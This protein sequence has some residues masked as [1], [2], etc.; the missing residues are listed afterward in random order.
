MISRTIA[1]ELVRVVGKFP[2]VL[3]AGPRDAGKTTLVRSVL[4]GIQYVS[5]EDL[6]RRLFAESDPKGFLRSYSD[7]AILDE[8]QRVPELL[9]HLIELL[10]TNPEHVKFVLMSSTSIPGQEEFMQSLK[11]KVALLNLMPLSFAELPPVGE[12]AERIINGG[13]PGRTGSGVEAFEWASNYIETFMERDLKSIVQVSDLR[14]FRQFLV[15][16]AAQCG[17]ILNLSSLGVALGISH[18]TAKAWIAALERSFIVFRLQP[19]QRDYG[20]RIVKTP[21]IFFVDTSLACAL[22]RIRD[23]QSLQ[24]HVAMGGLFENLIIAEY[25]KTSKHSPG[26]P[27]LFFWRHH[28]GIEV[29]CILEAAGTLY[30]VEIKATST[31]RPEFFAGLRKFCDLTGTPPSSASIVYGGDE[32]LVF[33]DMRASGWR[34]CARP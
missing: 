12:L 19:Y 1:Q 7:G 14:I 28:G 3:M 18:N 26:G 16:L 25:F 34:N 31:V 29:D 27:E 10:E 13:Y 17:Q 2:A 20:K 22:L 32:E 8:V 9:P 11:G 24:N 4:P 5:M 15:M 33:G 23:A 21:K 6:D 30:P